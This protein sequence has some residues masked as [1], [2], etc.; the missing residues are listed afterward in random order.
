MKKL[1]VLSVA[2]SAALFTG[3]ASANTAYDGQI[4]F[5]GKVVDQTCT[6]TSNQKNLTVTLPTVSTSAFN[7]QVGSTAGSTGFTIQLDNCKAKTHDVSSVRL[8]FLPTLTASTNL[9]KTQLLHETQQVLRNKASS[10]SNVGVEILDASLN[11]VKLGTDIG[12]Y[13]EVG[14]VTLSDREGQGVI[15]QY[16]ARYYAVEQAVTAGDVEATVQYNIVYN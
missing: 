9:S 2:L 16:H 14:K 12:Q 3:V 15:L 1:S 8:F 5:R 7:N 13:G 10:G 6:V 4:N 11:K